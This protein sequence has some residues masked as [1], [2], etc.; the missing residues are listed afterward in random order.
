MTRVYR[1]SLLDGTRP[2][3]AQQT[4]SKTPAA[5]SEPLTHTTE[6]HII[7]SDTASSPVPPVTTPPENSTPTPATPAA[8]AKPKRLPLYLKQLQSYN[9]PGLSE[10]VSQPRTEHRVTRQSSKQ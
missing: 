9:A 7:T 10:Q 1:R 6:R 5:I 2:P 8:A 4:L 3:T